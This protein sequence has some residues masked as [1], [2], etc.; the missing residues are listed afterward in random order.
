MNNKTSKRQ[1]APHHLHLCCSCHQYGSWQ[2][3]LHDGPRLLL[4]ELVGLGFIKP[5]DE[6]DQGFQWK[7][8]VN[9]VSYGKNLPSYWLKAILTKMD[10]KWCSD[11]SNQHSSHPVKACSDKGI[12]ALTRIPLFPTNIHLSSGVFGDTLIFEYLHLH[13][14]KDRGKSNDWHTYPTQGNQQRSSKATADAVWSEHGQ[15]SSSINIWAFPKIGVPQIGW[16]I[17][18][19]PIKMD[20]LGVPLFSETPIS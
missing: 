8:H 1:F 17:M 3:P 20:D 19:N 16:F 15:G 2:W 13:Q 7:Y 4:S 10:C 6:G 5:L 14:S 11:P 12:G 18:E 9:V